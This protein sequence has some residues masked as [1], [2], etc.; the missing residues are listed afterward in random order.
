M[1]VGV[2]GQQRVDIVVFDCQGVWRKEERGKKKK[3]RRK[4]RKKDDQREPDEDEAE[5]EG[6]AKEEEIQEPSYS[7]TSLLA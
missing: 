1:V 5:G 7:R 2:R 3:E 4:Q 6:E